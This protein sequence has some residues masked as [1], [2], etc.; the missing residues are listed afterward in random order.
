MTERTGGPVD[1]G[2]GPSTERPRSKILLVDDR[3]DNL[4]ALEAILASLDQELVTA[5][6]GEEALKRL[7]VDDFAVILLDVQM[8]GM[9]G[10]ETA[11]RIK[12]RGRTR[13]TPIIFLT[14]ID[15]EPHHAFRGYAV[16]AVDYIAK[17]FD[18]W[19]LRAKVSVFV[20][21]FEK[22]ERLGE[23]VHQRGQDFDLMTEV[24]ERLIALDVLLEGA[25][26]A[27][28]EEIIAAAG[29]EVRGLVAR[30]SPFARS[31]PT[32]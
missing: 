13:D 25:R 31:S 28:A 12:Q 23:L 9:D 15:R 7:L 2:G 19:L 30:M 1:P 5:S 16:G 18:P 11:H 21:L 3:P 26:D 14:A 17:P 29:A 4:M 8:P 27:S 32:S 22:N 10:F 24:A 20:E 6:S